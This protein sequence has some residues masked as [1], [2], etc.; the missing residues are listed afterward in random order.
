MRNTH[1]WSPTCAL[2]ALATGL[3]ACASLND[4][5]SS[6]FS[7]RYTCPETH[8]RVAAREDLDAAAVVRQWHAESG[9]SPAAPPAEVSADPARL[10][11][12]EEQRARA[13]AALAEGD[14][15][16]VSGC[17]HH[18]LYVCQHPRVRG[19]YY[20]GMVTCMGNPWTAAPQQPLRIAPAAATP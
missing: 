18:E 6:V 10:A 3:S 20:V 5:A 4:G 2:L 8:M 11:L 13:L 14:A 7:Q 16:E 12:W 19:T 9:T 1:D 15:F 17:G